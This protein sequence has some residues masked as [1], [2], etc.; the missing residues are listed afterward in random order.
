MNLVQVYGNIKK[1]VLNFYDYSFILKVYFL[2]FKF[3]NIDKIKKKKIIKRSFIFGVNLRKFQK[4]RESERLL[5]VL[6]IY[7]QNYQI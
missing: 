4:L 1:K 2:F 6:N 5:G 3:F 7:C